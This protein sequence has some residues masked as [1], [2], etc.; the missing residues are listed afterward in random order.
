MS[1]TKVSKYVLGDGSVSLIQLDTS[2][3]SLGQTLAIGPNNTLQFEDK[4]VTEDVEDI[5]AGLIIRG[6]HTNLSVA[7]IDGTNQLNLTATGAVSTVNTQTGDVVLGTDDILEGTTNLYYTDARAQSAIDLSTYATQTYVGTQI[8]NLIDAAPNALDTLNEIAAALN[9][10]ENFSTTITSSIST[11]LATAD[12]STTADTWI[13]TK[14]TSHLAE[15]SNLYFTDA[16]ARASISA[17]GSLSYNDAT[18]VMSFTMPAQTTTAIT[19]GTNLYFTDERAQDA[20]A[21]SLVAGTNTA[22]VYDDIANTITISASNAGGINLS[23]NDTDDL[24]EG[25]TNLYYT[26]TRVDTRLAQLI[27]INDTSE[28]GELIYNIPTSVID[29]SS[30]TT[31]E[32]RN[33]LGQG[34]GVFYNSTSGE[35][36]IGQAVDTSS[37]VQ[38]QDLVLTGNLTVSGVFTVVNTEIIALADNIILLNS[39]E[40][41]VASQSGGIEIERGTDINVSFLWDEANDRWS[42]GAED[43]TTSGTFLGNLSGTVTGTV[44]DISNHNTSDL[45]EGSNLYYT[46]TRWDDRLLS[47]DTDDLNEGLNLYFTEARARASI[48]ATGSLSYDNSTGVMSF[49]MPAQT[50]TAITEGTNLYYTAA[51]DTAQF[52]VDFT[53]KDTDALSEGSTNLYYTTTRSNT[54]FDTRLSTKDTDDLAEGVT[55]LY[56]TD[57]RT[58]TRVNILRTDLE[59]SGS[60]DL[61]F[62]NIT[63]LPEVT[64]DIITGNGSDV[65]FTLTASPGSA[66]AAIVT[67]QG[68][69]QL[70]G[71]DYTISTNTITMTNVLPS[72]QKA[73]V[74]HVGFKISGGTVTTASDAHLLDGLDSTQFLRSDTSDTMVGT[75]TMT[76]DILPSANVTYN[77]GSST[78]RW[79]E[80][81]LSTST[82]NLGDN[83]LSSGTNDEPLWNETSVVLSDLTTSIIPDLDN[84]YNLGSETKQF[85]SIYGHAVEAVYADLAER[86]SSDAEYDAGTVVVFGGDEEIT[87]TVEELDVSVAGIISTSPALKMNSLAG[88]DITHPYVALKGRVPCKV[89]GP[90]TKGDLLVTSSTPGFAKSV[91]KNDL[92]RAVFAKAIHTN[93]EQGEKL[94][95][96]AVI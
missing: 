73:L 65:T 51:R 15:G 91:G 3:G 62:D 13:G 49:T 57:T 92:G 33:T 82:I 6:T 45:T 46:T 70:P 71:V 54:D 7:Y 85:A 74:R 20:V 36:S 60:T 1:T 4:L 2:G 94:I 61:H 5:A 81:W 30:V 8:T 10:D 50:T 35:I 77:L 44:S 40:T 24:S 41:G 87:T 93:L 78:Q 27:V 9:D 32:I 38:F 34:T 53:A 84:T 47:K 21:S 18:G 29:F 83:T 96:V 16:R 42:L 76:G 43:L 14:T 89:I 56:Y 26:D 59:T 66:S 22:I 12:F 52:N 72:G 79:N 63:N 31:A 37:D 48:S 90:V 86:Y 64:T 95:E 25:A 80:L 58:D 88:N 75:L 67:V 11:K 69:T 23:Q 39:N 68:V 19:E 28:F 17:T 55:N